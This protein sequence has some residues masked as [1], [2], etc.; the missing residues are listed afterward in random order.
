MFVVWFSL[1]VLS[2]SIIFLILIESLELLLSNRLTA[3]LGF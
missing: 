1:R 3:L 2:H